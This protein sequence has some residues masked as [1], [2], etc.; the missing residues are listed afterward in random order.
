I[1][2]FLDIW[3][4]QTTDGRASW[5]SGERIFEGVVGALRGVTQLKSSR[6]L[7]PVGMWIT[8]R[9][10]GLPTG[11]HEVSAM[12]SDNNGATWKL[13]PSRLVAP[14]YEGFN[15]SNYGACEPNVLELDDGHVWMLMRTQTGLLYESHSHDSGTTWSDAVPSQFVSS[16]SPAEVM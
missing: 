2:L 3:H 9:K 13:S 16:D 4:W 11:G 7:L 6:I 15:G 8:G 14:C 10:A 5:T 12:D 1:D